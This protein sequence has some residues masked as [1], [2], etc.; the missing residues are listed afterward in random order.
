M[1]YKTTGMTLILA[2]SLLP[3]VFSLPGCGAQSSS[4]QASPPKPAVS[5][6]AYYLHGTIRCETCLAIEREAKAVV[7][8]RFAE[9]IGGG[10]FQWQAL[11]YE[12][13]EHAHFFKDFQLSHPDLV[14]ARVANGRI[15]E[16][17]VLE[18]T[19]D[20]IQDPHAFTR[21]VEEELSVFLAGTT[22][23]GTGK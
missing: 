10:S 1:A 17:K 5:V 11:D 20:L 2:A 9:H 6:V 19:W 21:Y 8:T 18:K 22:V 14:L 13:P 4:P 16:W 3:A 15:A 7:D 12:Q 23:D